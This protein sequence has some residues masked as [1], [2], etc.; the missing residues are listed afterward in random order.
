MPALMTVIA[1]MMSSFGP[2]AAL[3]SLSNSLTQTIASGNRVLS[4]LEEK[5]AVAD[6][7]DG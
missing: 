7:T 4:V 1:A 2:T 3:S 5:P 6:N